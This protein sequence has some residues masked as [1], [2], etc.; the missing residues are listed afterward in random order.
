VIGVA[1]AYGP[2]AD[3]AHEVFVAAPI[4]GLRLLLVRSVTVFVAA[5]L[6][7]ALGAL[8]SPTTG[9]WRVAWV[10]PALATTTGALALG[11]ALGVRRACGT[12][13]VGWLAV[14]ATVAQA[15]DDATAAFGVTGQVTSLVATTVAAFV[16]LA[17][18]RRLD[19]WDAR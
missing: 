2:R 18:R 1:F 7:A 17:R 14:V 8:S 4:S 3:R 10:L 12:V 19:R 13:A 11:T 6:L 16:L 9:W 5:G 15:V